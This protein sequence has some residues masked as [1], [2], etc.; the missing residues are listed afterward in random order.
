VT[1][2]ETGQLAIRPATL[3]Q[4]A[5]DAK[6]LRRLDFDQSHVY[7]IKAVDLKHVTALLEASPAYLARS[8][9]LIE[10]HLVGSRRKMV[11]TTSPTAQAERWK[12]ARVAKS[13]LWRVP[14]E[15]IERRSRLDWQMSAMWLKD[16]LPLYWVYQE[17]KA[18][19]ARTSMDPLEYQESLEPKGAQVVTNAAPLYRG[20]VLYLKGKFGEDGAAGYFRIARP[21]H[22][23]LARSSASDFEKQVKFRAKQDASYWLGLMAYQRGN[24]PSAID[25][26]LTKTIEAYPNGPWSTGARYNLGRTYEASGKPDL[27]ILLYI[28]NSASPGYL[29]DV[30]RAKWLKELGEKGKP[31]GE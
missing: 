4:V 7:G 5:A 23:S 16:V 10:L 15:T 30:L 25:Y 13:R 20:R 22:E 14:F 26:F 3:A 29:G 9:K 6:L 8:M 12:A 2:D 17:R 24:Y 21:S 31:G 28:S 27:A 19:G 11:L 18:G 1:L